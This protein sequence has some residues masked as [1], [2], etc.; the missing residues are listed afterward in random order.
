M[1]SMKIEID[2]LRPCI[3]KHTNEKALFHGFFPESRVVRPRGGHP[4]GTIQD[5]L[6][7]VEFEDGHVERVNPTHIYFL[8][9]KFK[10]YCFGEAE[11]ND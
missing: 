5:V 10:E 2:K 8:D 6:A 9:N 1:A 7:I 11:S 4:G 3:I